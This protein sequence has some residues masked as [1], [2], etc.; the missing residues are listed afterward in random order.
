MAGRVYDTLIPLPA[1]SDACLQAIGIEDFDDSDD[2]WDAN[3][4]SILENLV[5]GEE[6]SVTAWHPATGESELVDSAQLSD[7]VSYLACADHMH[8]II[9]SGKRTIRFTRGHAILW[10]EGFSQD[11]MNTLP[12][13]IETTDNDRIAELF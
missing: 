12:F 13:P 1:D 5:D 4:H 11:R 9:A 2:C 7:I 6:F 8:F 3:F 10:L